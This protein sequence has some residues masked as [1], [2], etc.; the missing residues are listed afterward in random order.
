M[1]EYIPKSIAFAA[2]VAVF[3]MMLMSVVYAWKVRLGPIWIG[4]WAI[5]CS[6]GT[7]L[8]FTAFRVTV[9]SC[10]PSSWMLEGCRIGTKG[11]SDSSIPPGD[12]TKSYVRR[13][14]QGLAYG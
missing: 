3:I 4:L 5:A 7:G 11:G 13:L 10:M 8:L 12:R 2:P 9:R 1:L 14:G 6:I